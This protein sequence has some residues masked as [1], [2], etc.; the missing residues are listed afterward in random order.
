MMR[1]F[2]L[3][4]LACAPIFLMAQ[5][6][7]KVLIEEWSN[8]SCAPCAS[9][10]P[11]FNAL[12]D[13]NTDKVVPI[14]Y[15][16]YFPGY[17]PFQEQNPDEVN[18][19]GEYYGLNGVPTAW[20]DGQLPDD[21]YAGGVGAWDIAGGGYEGGPYGYNQAAIDWA[22]SQVT[23]IEM[24]LSHSLNESATEVTVDVTITNVS[25]EAFA[26]Q[27]GRLQIALLEAEV[28]FPEAPGTNGE[29][30]FFSVMRKMYPDENG[31]TVPAIPAGE[32]WTFSITGAVPSYIYGLNQLKVVAFVQ[33]HATTE[34]FQ[35]A[36]T[37][38]Q[39]IANA[40]DAGFGDNLTAAPTSLCGGAITP[41]VEFTNGGSVD[42]TQAVINALINGSVIATQTFEGTLAAGETTTITFPEYVLVDANN[43]LTFSIS[44]V[45]NGVGVDINGLNNSTA[46][47]TYGA[48]SDTPIGTEL[49]EDN[50]AYIEAY[51]STALVIPSIPFGEFGGQS[52]AVFSRDE[53]TTQTGDPIGGYG[54]SDR[55]I[56]INFYQWNP[57]GATPDDASMTYQK[58]DLTNAVSPKLSF[59]RASASWIGDG[60][61]GDRLQ[62]LVSTDCAASFEVVWDASGATLN[63]APAQDPF[64]VPSAAHWV[65]E[66]IDM[67]AYAGQVVNVR[68]RAISAWGNNLFL[69]NINL[70][71]V[72]GTTELTEVAELTM[73]PN[74][75]KDVM[76]VRFDLAEATQLNVE[77]FNA[78]G[79]RVQ[80]LGTQSYVAGNNQLTV[81]AKELA[82][83]VYFLRMFNAD[84]ELNR[85]FVVQH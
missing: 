8:A 63:T 36:S 24:T 66:E 16:W 10:N 49:E 30:E 55:S 67:G 48:L 34:V 45:N 79:Q 25:T 31:T 65:T 54:L 47:V 59:D 42:I 39:P 70:S 3:L 12:L 7:R 72:V 61:S 78:M 14:K 38:P 69:D 44:E 62:V 60:V 52:F 43:V 11:A 41:T 20:I 81:D 57:A 68:F 27:D 37:E 2:L 29:T 71:D 33:D 58:I 76:T 23:P 18:N 21:D 84:R 4:V 26:M 6:Q 83:G 51:P 1:K 19:R 50:E 13:A 15:Q 85:R 5:A 46:A 64:Y 53:L 17:D 74:P 35:A 9:Q 73:F 80:V 82:N 75:V 40:I 56:F 32:S 77:V 22:Y 28:A